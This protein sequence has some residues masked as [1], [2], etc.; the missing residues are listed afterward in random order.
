MDEEKNMLTE[1]QEQEQE[2]R[3]AFA[4]T[5]DKSAEWALKKIKEAEREQNRLLELI[6]GERADLDIRE[7]QI[8]EQYENRT[9]HLKELLHNYVRYVYE[10]G[11]AS[12]TKT[13]IAYPLISGKLVMKKPTTKLQP[14]EK[15]LTEW[16][17][18]HLP[19]RVKTTY[20]ADWAEI[21]KGVKVVD[22]IAVYEPTGEVMEGVTEQQVAPELKIV[23]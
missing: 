9:S 22:G 21:K 6:D 16:C 17:R 3:D 12:E 5:D 11:D 18:T 2:Q 14:D 8:T 4:I 1:E 13:Q 7:R 10:N 19:E 15:A 20:K 23:W